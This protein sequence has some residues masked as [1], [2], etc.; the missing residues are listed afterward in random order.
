MKSKYKVFS[1]AALTAVVMFASNTGTAEAACVVKGVYYSDDE[2][3]QV[4]ND[5]NYSYSYQ[6]S[7]QNQMQIEMMQRYIEQLLA[8]LERLKEL[9]ASGNY[10]PTYPSY[11]NSDVDV[12]TRSAT[13]IDDDAATLRGRVDFN[14]EDEAT[15]YFRYGYSRSDLDEETVHVVLDEDDDDEDF[16]QRIVNLR[17]DRTY[18]FR[19]IAEDEDGRKDY[20]SILS[21]RT[22]DDN[23]SSNDDE[24]DIDGLI[25]GLG[26]SLN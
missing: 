3:V 6:Y 20:G 15:V 10:Y 17:E 25:A 9:Q 16:S 12:T 4:K 18:Y 13:D 26:I 8:I 11:G 5:Y 2:C 24:P 1:I 21:F 22:D 19:A 23:H 14:S 7:Y